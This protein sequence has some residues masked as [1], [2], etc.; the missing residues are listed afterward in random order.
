MAAFDTVVRN[1]KVA[2][3][4]DVF[5]AD[6]GITDGKIAALGV[7]LDKG[8][9]EI[10]ATGLLVTPGGIDSHCHVEQMGSTGTWTADDWFTG[11]RSAACGG[12][13]TIMPFACQLRGQS[14]RQ[15][16]EDYHERAG[17]KGGGR[18]CLPSDR[19]RPH[20]AGRRSGAARADQGRLH[21][22]QDLPDI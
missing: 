7:D 20:R 15:V 5:H 12:T 16:V 17:P 18:L 19:F 9:E 13:T 2:T 14:L 8:K 21:Q 1:G 6:I 22:L 10:D 11:T 3:A 4:S